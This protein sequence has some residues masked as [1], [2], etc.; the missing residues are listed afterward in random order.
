[1]RNAFQVTQFL[2]NEVLSTFADLDNAIESARNHY[3]AVMTVTQC[4]VVGDYKIPTVVFTV[5]PDRVDRA[6]LSADDAVQFLN[7]KGVFN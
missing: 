3:D 7:K 2:S 1:M 4:A 6:E 5:Y